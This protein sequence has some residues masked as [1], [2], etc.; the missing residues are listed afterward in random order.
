LNITACIFAANWWMDR[1]PEDTPLSAAIK[2]RNAVYARMLDWTK[3]EVIIQMD[4]DPGPPLDTALMIAQLPP[5]SL[6]RKS[7]MRVTES[8]VE[9]ACGY[10]APFECV[11]RRDE[12]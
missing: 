11:W 8:L 3:P 12:V 7:V 10:G 6:P 1:L 9:A 4:Y 5:D 2:F